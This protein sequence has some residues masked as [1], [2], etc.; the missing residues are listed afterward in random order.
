MRRGAPSA[1]V[2]WEER[3]GNANSEDGGLQQVA[4]RE[5]SS[6][7]KSLFKSTGSGRSTVA[8][9]HDLVAAMTPLETLQRLAD[10]VVRCDVKAHSDRHPLAA[11]A[12][13]EGAD[14]LF[15][16]LLDVERVVQLAPRMNQG[17]KGRVLA[18]QTR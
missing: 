16:P 8:F 5:A 17:P 18:F 10:P 1:G 14:A 9:A 2:F 11:A 4:I 3:G 15:V 7:P 12:S 6:K 13:E